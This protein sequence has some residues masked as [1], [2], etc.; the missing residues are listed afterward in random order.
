MPAT[1]NGVLCRPAAANDVNALT[2]SAPGF[3]ESHVII[4]IKRGGGGENR[5]C[6]SSEWRGNQA[7]GV[8]V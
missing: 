5:L 4:R 3:I 6:A 8:R 2:L 7:A 1:G